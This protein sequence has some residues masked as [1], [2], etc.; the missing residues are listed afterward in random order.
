MA[1]KDQHG[2]FRELLAARLDRPL[3]RVESRALTTHLK[4]CA[5]CQQVDAEYRANRAQ[6]RG[7]SQPLPPRDMWARTSSAL[8]REVARG[9]RTAWGRRVR[10][11]RRKAQPS[12]ALM[13]TIA[14]ASVIAALAVFQLA[15]AVAPSSRAPDRPT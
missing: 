14:A 15:P 12:T 4:S 9:A 6:L 11:A 2:P 7:L 3:T 5:T 1:R 8:D 13:S 10:R